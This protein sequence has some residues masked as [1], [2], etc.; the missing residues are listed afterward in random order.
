MGGTNLI[1]MLADKVSS[2]LNCPAP[3]FMD[4]FTIPPPGVGDTLK[5]IFPSALL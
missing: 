3:S 4:I 1:S 2:P 5:V